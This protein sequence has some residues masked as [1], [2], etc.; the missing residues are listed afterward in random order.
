MGQAERQSHADLDRGVSYRCPCP[1][2]VTNPT[3][4]QWRD[5]YM[6]GFAKAAIDLDTGQGLN[7]LFM[8]GG[9]FTPLIQGYRA[10]VRAARGD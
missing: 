8:V 4:L 2:P 6:A 7:P 10:G 1:E 3:I 5:A 9:A